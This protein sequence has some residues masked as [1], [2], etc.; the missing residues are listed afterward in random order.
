MLNKKT[1]AVIIPI[2]NGD[3]FIDKLYNSIPDFVDRIIFVNNNSTDNSLKLLLKYVEENK[4]K[5][6]EIKEIKYKITRNLYNNAE[7]IQIQQ[8][9][10]EKKYLSYTENLEINTDLDKVI[11]LNFTKNLGVGSA[12][13][14]GYKWAKDRNIDCIVTLDDKSILSQDDFLSICKPII[15]NNVDYVKG[16]RVIHSSSLL[17]YPRLKYLVFSILSA[18]TKLASGYWQLSDSQSVVTAISLNAL[19]GL[20]IFRLSKNSGFFNDI[21][22]RLNI[23]MCSIREVPIKQIMLSQE[24]LQK[25]KFDGF[26][27]NIILLINLFFKRLYFKYLF[28]D[29]HPLF[30]LYHL[31]FI[32]F[33]LSIP[34]SIEIILRLFIEG[35][36]ITDIVL[37][38]YLFLIITSYQSLLFAMWM[39]MQDNERL[40]K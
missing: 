5:G 21:L 33:I 26:T 18:L 17:I 14:N 13:I 39:D 37:L 29:F 3:E 31:S 20:K 16:S 27:Q 25:Q 15:D 38:V 28:R 22:V 30:L 1:I 23:A 6:I 40:N 10:I 19:K 4:G 34:L 8:S 36:I 24:F 35:S 32:I 9:E 11:L 12:I 7:I 2:Y